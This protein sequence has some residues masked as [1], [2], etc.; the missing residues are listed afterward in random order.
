MYQH[1]GH[2]HSSPPPPQKRKKKRAVA[3]AC[4]AKLLCVC[5]CGDVIRSKWFKHRDKQSSHPHYQKKKNPPPHFVPI[6]R[7]CRHRPRPEASRPSS[8]PHCGVDIG[9]V[10]AE[11]MRDLLQSISRKHGPGEYLIALVLCTS[12]AAQM[13]RHK[14]TLNPKQVNGKGVGAK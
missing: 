9:T 5:I 2:L 14:D 7:P 3:K 4:R 11:S 10:T 12:M 6:S 1:R 8:G 13:W